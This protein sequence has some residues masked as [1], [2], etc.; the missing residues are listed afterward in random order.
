VF[1]WLKLVKFPRTFRH[2]ENDNLKKNKSSKDFIR[3]SKITQN[4]SKD[5]L[6]IMSSF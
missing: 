6:K 5:Y 2:N 4:S 1:D 3:Q